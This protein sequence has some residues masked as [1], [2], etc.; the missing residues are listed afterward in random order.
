MLL[1]LYLRNPRLRE[2]LSP[3]QGQSS[4]RPG[5]R[6]QSP[7]PL[8]LFAGPRGGGRRG[9]PPGP[10]REGRPARSQLRGEG[11]R[12]V[13]DFEDDPVAGTVAGA[14][15]RTRAGPRPHTARSWDPRRPP[16]PLRG[17]VPAASGSLRTPLLARC[18]GP[19]RFRLL[20]GPI[21]GVRPPSAP[22]PLPPP[23][24][25]CPG[26]V[27]CP[28]RSAARSLPSRRYGPAGAGP[29][30]CGTRRGAGGLLGGQRRARRPGR[31]PRA[32][33]RRGRGLGGPGSSGRA[34]GP[35]PSR[36]SGAPAPAAPHRPPP[37]RPGRGG[38]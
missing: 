2:A 20:P 35:S 24:R 34:W 7:C 37:L 4:V 3:A 38:V 11:G 19:P 32:P 23:P 1:K 8:L 9:A 36:G 14:L 12:A 17:A 27:A 22:P 29:R 25:C 31:A 6:A 5:R 13:R 10:G 30:R 21:S 28:G 33:G 18:P 16:G 26:P 15:G